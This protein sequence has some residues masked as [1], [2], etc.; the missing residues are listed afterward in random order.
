MLRAADPLGE[1]QREV[2]ASL[3]NV[4][5]MKFRHAADVLTTQLGYIR[6]LRGHPQQHE[7]DVDERAF[8]GNP[9]QPA[10]ECA[11]WIR[12]LQARFTAGHYA[13]A[14]NARSRA[15][16]LLW[17]LSTELAN[18]EFHFYGALSLAACCPSAAAGEIQHLDLIHAHHTR[19]RAWER[20]C[21]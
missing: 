8:T 20:N 9:D 11:Y 4:R 3:H 7:E 17:T 12:V 14:G 5:K 2:E 21:R 13:A 19:L 18:A 16:R 10:L 15:E 1:T 6:T